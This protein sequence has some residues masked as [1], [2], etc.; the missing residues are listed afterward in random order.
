MATAAGVAAAVIP[1][2]ADSGSRGGGQEIAVQQ[3]GNADGDLFGGAG[4]GRARRGGQGR[5]GTD[6]QRSHPFG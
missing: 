3:G 2:V 6:K 5:R 4:A 1:A